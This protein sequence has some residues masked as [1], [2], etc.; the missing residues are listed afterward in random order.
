MNQKKLYLDSSRAKTVL[1]WN[2]QID[3]EEGLKLTCEW[4]RAYFSGESMGTFS[5]SQLN[6]YFKRMS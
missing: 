1:N 5:F 2:P 3:I 6:Q 4:Y